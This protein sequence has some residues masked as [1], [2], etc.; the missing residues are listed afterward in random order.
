MSATLH[1]MMFQR[2][3]GYG[4]IRAQKVMEAVEHPTNLLEMPSAKLDSLRLLTKR[5][6]SVLRG[7]EQ[8]EREAENALDKAL[9][10]GCTVL[11]PDNDSYPRRLR[12]IY[13]PPLVLYVLGS[14]KG[15]DE[16]PAIGMV[17]TRKY[18][19]YGKQVA[20]DLSRQLAVRGTAII[21]GLA[22]G[23][24]TISHIAALKAGGRT[25]AVLGNGLDIIYPT[26]NTELHGLIL[27]NGGA[28]VS[29]FPPGEAP[30]PFHFPIR[31]RII[32]G[33]SLGVVVVE[34]T[35][36]SGSLITAGHAVTQDRDVF[37][38]PGEIYS[39]MS[40]AT[41]WL[42]GQGATLVT[43]AQD[44]IDQ[45]PYISFL[46]AAHQEPV[47]ISFDIPGTTVYN[48]QKKPKPAAKA[49]VQLEDT[50]P[51]VPTYLSDN[52]RRVLEQLSRQPVTSDAIALATGLTV[53]S[54]LASLTQL[55]IFGLADAC[56]GRRFIRK[57]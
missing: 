20:D 24:D 4:T 51:A 18:T 39:P 9:R 30:L 35:R 57:A 11:T 34:G 41:N 50:M 46:P 56:A 7:R 12:N 2:V 10:L 40:Q 6:A 47:Q 55:E 42:I 29:E 38:V 28:V 22:A 13:S 49:K 16:Q 3:F 8:L 36:H 5:E 26:S 33:L 14:L 19:D 54:I 53:P 21:S 32:S 1:W 43:C 25:V 27:K 44:V 17:G 52:Q 37:A 48:E 23:I 15:L 31:N 45:Y